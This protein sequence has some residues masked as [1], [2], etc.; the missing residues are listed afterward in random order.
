MISLC[1][2][3]LGGIL[4]GCNSSGV[5]EIA[6]VPEVPEIKPVDDSLLFLN[7]SESPSIEFLGTI[8]T[9]RS[10]KADGAMLYPGDTVGVFL[11]AIFTHAAI[12][13]GAKNG[14]QAKLQAEA[15]KILEPY[16]EDIEKVTPNFLVDKGMS[17]RSR[18]VHLYDSNTPQ[19][20][21][22]LVMDLKPTYYL[23]Q[24][25]DALSLNLSGRVYESRRSAE[26]IDTVSIQY[27]STSPVSKMDIQ[28]D[29]DDAGMSIDI[30]EWSKNIFELALDLYWSSSDSLS[31]AAQTTI[32][33]RF[34]SEAKSERGY[35]IRKDCDRLTFK[36]LHGDIKS[37]PL[38]GGA[39]CVK[40]LTRMN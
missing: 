10:H 8:N 7:F 14:K 3:L 26:E 33:Y 31:S 37:V 9:D 6:S 35:L 23:S 13:A 22:V 18:G 5:K 40:T 39:D 2:L 17:L 4:S 16:F 24:S 36:T 30:S 1:I 15:D 12:N 11:A 38:G 28:G 20:E 19:S 34:G 25:E 32:R 29:E 21:N 27:I